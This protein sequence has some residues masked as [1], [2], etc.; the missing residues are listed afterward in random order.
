V[1]LEEN[2]LL[3]LLEENGCKPCIYRKTSQDLFQKTGR[4]DLHPLQLPRTV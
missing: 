1:L 3:N 4:R 2:A